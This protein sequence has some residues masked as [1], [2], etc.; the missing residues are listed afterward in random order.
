[1]RR[2]TDYARTNAPA[3]HLYSQRGRGRTGVGPIRGHH[4][5]L[6][7]L[8][9]SGGRYAGTLGR[10]WG[11]CQGQ[12]GPIKA[13]LSYFA[14]SVFIIGARRTR[15]AAT[16]APN[17]GIPAS[18]S[19]NRRGDQTWR[20]WG[21]SRQADFAPPSVPAGRP[22]GNSPTSDGRSKSGLA[23]PAVPPLPPRPQAASVG[24]LRRVA[25][26]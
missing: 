14:A 12:S 11:G 9:T 22:A 16:E 6:R 25:T 23:P 13:P 21:R 20:L 8:D 2:T 7:G 24:D 17:Q 15:E 19:G 18:P 3:G 5:H 26:L 10:L 1:M 4:C